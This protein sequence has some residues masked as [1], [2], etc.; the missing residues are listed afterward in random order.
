[1]EDLVQTN[2]LLIPFIY[3]KLS[4]QL[5]NSEPEEMYTTG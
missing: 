1:M 2:T 5:L 3:M 4:F